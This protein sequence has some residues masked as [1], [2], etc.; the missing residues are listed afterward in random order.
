MIRPIRYTGP[1]EAQ[2]QKVIALR[3]QGHTWI[4]IMRTTGLN[5]RAVRKALISA[6]LVNP[7]RRTRGRLWRKEMR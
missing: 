2:R 5:Y 3:R 4:Y 7:M 6:E 1:T